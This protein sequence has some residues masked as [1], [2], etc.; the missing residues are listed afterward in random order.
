MPRD[1]FHEKLGSLDES[2]EAT[3]EE[4][5]DQATL[6]LYAQWKPTTKATSSKTP[7]TGDALPGWLPS[8]LIA[9]ALGSAMMALYS[10]RR[11][12]MED[13]RR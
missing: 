5:T 11:K 13:E 4:Y 2:D 8:M 10:M 3:A 7:K 9:F 1:E 6:D 12:R